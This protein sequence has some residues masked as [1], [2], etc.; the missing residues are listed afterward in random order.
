MRFLKYFPMSMV[1]ENFSVDKV[2]KH[3]DNISWLYKFFWGSHIHHGYWEKDESPQEAQENLIKK[4]VKEAGLKG[5]ETVLDVGC[6]LGGS[7]RW[8][9][10]NLECLVTGITLSPKQIKIATELTKKENLNSQVQFQ[11]MD[12]HH[13]SFPAE[14]Y[15]VV[16]VVECSEHLL[17]KNKFIQEVSRILRP[18]GKLA[19]CG[20]M[21]S[22]ESREQKNLVKEICE[23]MILPSIGRMEDYSGW[24]KEAG[25]EVIMT[26]DLTSQVSRTWDICTEISRSWKVKTLLNFLDQDARRFVESF[27]MM[28][29]AYQTHSMSYGLF[30][31]IKNS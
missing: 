22:S 17:D 26:Q 14:S 31:A 13:L 18:G 12:A 8:L 11:L 4:L 6:G 21:D 24:M 28:K 5:K 19:L 15:D 25:L 23:R 29:E 3:Y 1:Q 2:R 10:R 30:I 16:W 9:A 7:S 20:W 27:P